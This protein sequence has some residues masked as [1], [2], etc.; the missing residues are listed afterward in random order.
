MERTSQACIPSTGIPK[1]ELPEGDYEKLLARCRNLPPHQGDYAVESF[2]S[3][4]ILTVLD[5]Q[6]QNSVVKKMHDKFVQARGDYIRDIYQLSEVLNRY[7]NDR[8]GNTEAAITLWGYKHWKRLEQLRGLV[9][10]FIQIGV[11]DADSLKRWATTAMFKSDFKGRVKGLGPAV[12]QWLV[13]RAGVETIK[14]DVHV[15]NFVS[16]VIGYSPGFDAIIDSLKRIANT[17]GKTPR[18]LDWAIWEFQ[19]GSPG[20]I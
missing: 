9:S 18:Q 17:I 1:L 8:Q 11:T 13:M 12:F 14:P 4:V 3:N 19:R 16:S 6:L 15:V 10:Y 7:P 20:Q 2:L 5:Y